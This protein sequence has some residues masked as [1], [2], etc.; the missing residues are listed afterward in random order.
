MSI[1]NVAIFL[2]PFH[3]HGLTR[4]S[5]PFFFDT[6][7]TRCEFPTT[8]HISRLAQNCNGMVPRCVLQEYHSNYTVFWLHQPLVVVMTF[9]ETEEKWNKVKISI[10]N[11]WIGP[12]KGHKSS[13]KGFSSAC[14]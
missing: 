9:G 13:D 5:S 11:G 10:N 8:R 2:P 4:Y 3:H 1:N 14:S 6:G 7:T 12:L